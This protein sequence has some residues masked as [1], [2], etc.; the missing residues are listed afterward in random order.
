MP[1]ILLKCGFNR[2]ETKKYS[3]KK[4]REKK[5]FTRN[6]WFAWLNTEYLGQGDFLVILGAGVCLEQSETLGVQTPVVA[7][8]L[9]G[10]KRFRGD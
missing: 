9:W 8:P 2:N 7:S 1:P 10:E 4:E 5:Q 3:R 6:E